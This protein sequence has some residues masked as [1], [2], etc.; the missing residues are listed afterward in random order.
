MPLIQCNP[1]HSVFL[2]LATFFKTAVQKCSHGFCENHKKTP[3]M[4]FFQSRRLQLIKKGLHQRFFPVKSCEEHL[5][6]TASESSLGSSP[7]AL[8]Y[9]F[10]LSQFEWDTPD[11]MSI[12]RFMS[13]FS[14]SV[15]EY[16]HFSGDSCLI[17]ILDATRVKKEMF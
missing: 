6:T 15:I 5:R 16:K 12:V 14:T 11:F 2:L 10:Q 4:E 7:R 8:A 17:H 3:V 9:K 13:S 1:F